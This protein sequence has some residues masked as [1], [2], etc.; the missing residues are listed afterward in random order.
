MLQECGVLWMPL[1]VMLSRDK[2]SGPFLGCL[3]YTAKWAIE[4][5]MGWETRGS[6]IWI[7]IEVQY[8][9]GVLNNFMIKLKLHCKLNC[10]I[11]VGGDKQTELRK[12]KVLFN[13]PHG[14]YTL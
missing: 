7:M 13:C 11:V 5:D 12:V 10:K 1:T 8:E 6:L 4:G 14:N 2:P 9:D 3:K